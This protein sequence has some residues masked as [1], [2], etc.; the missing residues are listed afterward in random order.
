[1]ND[2]GDLIMFVLAVIG[3]VA[4]I[5]VAALILIQGITLIKRIDKALHQVD[6]IYLV[7]SGK[8]CK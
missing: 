8:E 6:S 4:C 7:T 3:F 5:F 2:T 1:M